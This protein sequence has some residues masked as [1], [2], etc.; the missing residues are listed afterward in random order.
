MIRIIHG[1]TGDPFV[2]LNVDPESHGECV[3][4]LPVHPGGDFDERGRLQRQ[5]RPRWPED[6]DGQH[7]RRL[8]HRLGAKTRSLPGS[9]VSSTSHA[10]LRGR[11]EQV[12]IL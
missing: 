3:R 12:G 11:S 6:R 10:E 9:R 4:E 8:T 7:Q 5:W 2:E 1:R